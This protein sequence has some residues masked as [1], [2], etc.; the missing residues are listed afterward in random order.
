M[1]SRISELL[2]HS[3]NPDEMA[4]MLAELAELEEQ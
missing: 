1:A 3:T 4:M 2:V